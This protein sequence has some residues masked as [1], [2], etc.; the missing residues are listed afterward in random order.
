M[1]FNPNWAVINQGSFLGMIV[2]YYPEIRAM[3][4]SKEIT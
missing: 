2:K 3:F 4:L 1:G